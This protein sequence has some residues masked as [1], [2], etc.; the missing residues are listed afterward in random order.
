LSRTERQILSTL[1]EQDSLSAI[2]LFFAVQQREDPPFMGDGS[3]FRNL[4]EMAFA[5]HPPIQ[6]EDADTKNI[7]RSSVT[8]TEIGHRV[9]DGKADHVKLNGID[10]W[11]GGVHLTG[12]DAAWRWDEQ[13]GRL[14]DLRRSR[15]SGKQHFPIE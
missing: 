3:F 15:W 10:R 2:K 11:L 6:I 4:R 7:A 12:T 14:S 8:I 9:L 13:G 1:R 5:R